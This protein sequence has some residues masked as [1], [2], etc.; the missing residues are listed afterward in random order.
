MWKWLSSPYW[1][2]VVDGRY[3]TQKFF[4]ERDLANDYSRF[5][6][7]PNTSPHLPFNLPCHPF[8]VGGN[9]NGG[10]VVP[11]QRIRVL[12]LIVGRQ[13]QSNR[14]VQMSRK[15][16]R[17][18]ALGR[19]VGS[20]GCRDVRHVKPVIRL[21]AGG[22]FLLARPCPNSTGSLVRWRRPTRQSR[23][24]YVG[25]V[26]HSRRRGWELEP[27]PPDFPDSRA[28]APS[29]TYAVE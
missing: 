19:A 9:T 8:I 15:E 1:C 24:L 23:Q 5:C 2:F 13:I 21:V 3:S 16:G 25:S 17:V 10:I 4:V 12:R 29:R 7:F 22:P 18:E 6:C 28:V 14:A 20:P 27:K 26:P 11:F